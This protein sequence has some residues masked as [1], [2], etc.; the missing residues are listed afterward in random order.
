MSVIGRLDEQVNEVLI[1]PLKKKE[2]QRNEPK[3]ERPLAGKTMP[4]ESVSAEK[5]QVERERLPVWLL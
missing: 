5:N 3:D 4:T 1:E 2:P